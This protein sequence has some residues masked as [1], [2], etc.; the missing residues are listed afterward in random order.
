MKRTRL[1]ILLLFAVGGLLASVDRVHAQ[2]DEVKRVDGTTK[3]G[4]VTAI[5]RT[6][7]TLTANTLAE[8]IPVNEI[9]DVIFTG[10][11]TGLKT[12]RLNAKNARYEDARSALGGV[13]MET[14]K[15]NEIKQEIVYLRALCAAHINLGGGDITTEQALQEMLGFVKSNSQSYHFFNACQILG[16]LSIRKGDFAGAAKYYG[17]LAKAPWPGY[18]MRAGVLAGRADQAQGKNAA[19]IKKFNYVLGLQSDTAE[20]KRQRAAATLGKSV[21]LATDASQVPKVIKVVKK[22][23]DE[24]AP[25]EQELQARA[26]NALGQCHVQAGQTKD[27]LLAFL[28]VD[29]LFHTVPEAHAE[30]LANLVDLWKQVD[31]ADRSRE[32]AEVLKSRYPNSRWAKK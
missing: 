6:E 4:K 1:V 26:Y 22:V 12:A 3:G 25:E 2:I 32:A 9:A 13:K 30:A 8:K 16:D 10:E 23:I 14:V 5:S 31:K 7:V 20:G 21:S 29:V 24:A 19:A 11:P 27:A 15:R 18:K 17:A 28:H